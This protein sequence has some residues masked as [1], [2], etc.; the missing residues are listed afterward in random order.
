MN[1]AVEVKN[2][3]FSYNTNTNKFLLKNINLTIQEGEF[4]G[5]AGANGSGKSTFA[6]MLNALLL[7]TEGTVSIFGLD[8][9]E[10]KNLFAIRRQAG[11]VF[12]NPDN[13]TVATIVEDDVAFGVENL[14]IA[15]PEMIERVNFALNA[16]GMQDFK[17]RSVAKLSG[18]QK[19]KIA[20][21][22][23]LAI[24]PKILILDE[25]TAMLDPKGRKE[26]MQIAQKLNK[27]QGMT[28]I[29]ITHFMDELLLADRA[30]V[31]HD[32]EIV[33]DGSPKEIFKNSARLQEYNLALPPVAHIV[34]CLQQNGISF[35]QVFQ[36]EAFVEE[37]C[38][39]LQQN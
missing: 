26:I 22:G 6:K 28:I 15:R 25:A 39:L 38:K 10:S 1:Y 13:Q 16:V 24:L 7:P 19:Q 2:L 20:I 4:I 33:L 12:Q 17:N 18:G 9:K 29:A 30:I 23:M 34:Q 5:I 21:A 32:G 37:I 14:A 36:E 35:E 11:M 27:E 31:L 8:T 3:N